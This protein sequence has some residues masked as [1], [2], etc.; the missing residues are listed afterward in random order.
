MNLKCQTFLIKYDRI[1]L[2]N[3]IAY[4]LE[5]AA[6]QYT[7]SITALTYAFIYETTRN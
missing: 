4:K 7:N 6:I 1:N 2:Y 3:S 5:F